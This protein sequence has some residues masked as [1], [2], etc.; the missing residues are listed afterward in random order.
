MS[1]DLIIEVEESLKKERAEALWKEYGPYL[2]AGVLVAVL[3]TAFISGWRSWQYKVNTANTALMVQAMSSE[4]VPAAL[5]EIEQALRP[6][7]KAVAY[8]SHVGI[9]LNEGQS[10]EALTVLREAAAD[11]SIPKPYDQLIQLQTARIAWEIEGA[12]A[13]HQALLSMLQPI[14]N[15][16]Q[17]PWYWHAKLQMALILGHDLKDYDQAHLHLTAI[18]QAQDAPETLV[19]RA[20][21]VDSM[22]R[23]ASAAQSTDA[24]SSNEEP[25]G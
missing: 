1:N 22:F 7:Q 18:R 15:N 11:K 24:S 14:A 21:A 17:S 9:L 20:V 6:G 13:D 2:I 12:E 23:L 19:Q 3:L 4:D 10:E 16:S 8:L 5:G 25:E